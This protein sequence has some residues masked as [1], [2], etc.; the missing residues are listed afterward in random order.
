[1]D[2]GTYKYG[3]TI[4]VAFALTEGSAGV[5]TAVARLWAAR[6]TTQGSSGEVI[7]TASG[8]SNPGNT[9]RDD[10][11]TGQWIPPRPTSVTWPFIR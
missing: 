3:R 9:F 8:G 10:P 6:T 4:P 2:G 1:V 5:R 11:A 7:A